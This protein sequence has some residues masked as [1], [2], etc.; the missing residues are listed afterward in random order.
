MLV[1]H[2]PLLGELAAFLS[3]SGAA[4]DLKKGGLCKISFPGA[5]TRGKGNFEWI[6][7]PKELKQ[8]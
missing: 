1:G 8:E 7:K 6:M 3:G 4:L 5:P 2:S